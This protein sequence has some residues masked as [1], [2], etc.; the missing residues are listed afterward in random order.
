MKKSTKVFLGLAVLLV[1]AIV[2]Y[3]LAGGTFNFSA[4]DAK[5]SGIGGVKKAEKYKSDKVAAELNMKGS[6]VQELLQ[7]D[8]FQKMIKDDKFREL[9][10]SPAF[11]ELA[12]NAQFMEL[13][14]NPAF[15][16]LA[17]N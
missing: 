2:G 4:D 6:E 13:A 9:M 8:Q 15:T 3:Y 11:T 16:D 1:V 14:K 17:R 10:K 12:K 7:N 5:G